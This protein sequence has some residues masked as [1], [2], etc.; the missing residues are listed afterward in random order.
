MASDF[1]HCHQKSV[2]SIHFAMKFEDFGNHVVLVLEVKLPTNL[3]LT[4]TEFAGVCFYV[5]VLWRNIAEK[6]I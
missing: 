3:Y 5:I 6:Q 4:F 2:L 1:R